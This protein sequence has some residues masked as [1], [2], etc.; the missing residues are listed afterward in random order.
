MNWIKAFFDLF[1]PRYCL[2]C[3]RRLDTQCAYLCPK[4]LLDLPRIPYQ[5]DELS[6]IQQRIQGRLSVERAASFMYYSPH[7]DSSQFLLHLKYKGEA[8]IGIHFGRVFAHELQSKGFFRDIDLLVPVP[9]S[10]RRLR[11]RGYNQSYMIA[12]GVSEVTGIPIS[13]K[14][15]ARTRDNKSQTHKSH[16]MRWEDS[17][18]LF[19]VKTFPTESQ[20]HFLLIDDIIT[21]GATLCAC[22]DALRQIPD[23]R[24]S[25]LT[26]GITR[27]RSSQP[28][29][30]QS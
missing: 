19:E 2:S 27:W 15:L 13:E 29:Q 30:P 9:L 5:E 20:R 28:L 14:L 26:L 17:K 21:T 4:C 24:I 25:L 12:L 16:T 3:S 8:Q 18:D 6:P 22:A 11:Q 23:A 1:F 10:A 7:A